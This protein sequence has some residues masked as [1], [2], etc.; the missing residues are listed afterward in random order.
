MKVI[1]V[2]KL[3]ISTLIF[4]FSS[5]N[6]PM[7]ASEPP[8]IVQESPTVKEAPGVDLT[9]PFII[10]LKGHSDLK[11]ICVQMASP[12]FA[13]M[14]SLELLLFLGVMP[15]VVLG[16]YSNER[17]GYVVSPGT[18]EIR[19]EK[20]I[21]NV[22]TNPK[23]YGVHMQVALQ[24]SFPLLYTAPG[25]TGELILVPE[26]KNPAASMKSLFVEYTFLSF[27]AAFQGYKQQK[28]THIHTRITGSFS[29]LALQCIAASLIPSLQFTV[30]VNDMAQLT[31]L[32]HLYAQH[33]NQS[34]GEVLQAL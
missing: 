27:Y 31:P 15:T 22:I 6:E 3:I 1:N 26:W 10:G 4:L 24:K 30:H 34:V 19:L 12:Q 8:Q 23:E 13:L 2:K 21:G 17:G 18:E 29:H 25:Y 16:P 14:Q 9:Q 32:Q 33:R 5:F 20:A 7:L 11:N 28:G